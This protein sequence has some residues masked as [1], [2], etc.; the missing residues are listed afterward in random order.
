M[1]NSRVKKTSIL[2]LHAGHYPYEKWDDHPFIGKELRALAAYFERVIVLC[3]PARD[4]RPSGVHGNIE[5]PPKYNI[6]PNGFLGKLQI[7]LFSIISP[8]TYCEIYRTPKIF[9]SFNAFMYLLRFVGLTEI[10]KKWLKKNIFNRSEYNLDTTIFYTFNLD[11]EAMAL[12]LLKEKWPEI[13]LISRARGFD[14]QEERYSLSYIP[15]REST[16]KNVDHIYFLSDYGKDYMVERYPQITGKSSV[17]PRG[18]DIPN[19]INP[20]SNDGVI[21]FV[22]C[23][24]VIPLKRVDLIAES[25]VELAR[26]FPRQ[27][28]KWT[29]IGDGVELDRIVNM[30]KRI[31]PNNLQCTFLGRI[32]NKSVIDHY[33]N[34]SVDLFIHMSRMEG[35]RPSAIQEALSCGIPVLAANVGGVSEL[36]TKN[37]GLMLPADPGVKDIVSAISCLL[38]NDEQLFEYRRNSQIFAQ[39]ELDAKNNCRSFAEHL[40]RIFSG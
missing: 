35:G 1:V 13:K 37:V 18:I 33:R 20:Q 32:P 25:I 10:N 30:I 38:N 14:F 26:Q 34:N 21:R 11:R 24:N 29:H 5:F 6:N 28:Y 7:V 27:N 2:V 16:L 12:G 17:S 3:Y 9:T 36:M 15:F 19:F 39:K 8:L 23:S 4:K 31:S 40:T 22:S